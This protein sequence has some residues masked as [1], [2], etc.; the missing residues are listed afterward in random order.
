M[1]APMTR[2]KFLRRAF[3]GLTALGARSATA[4]IPDA[5]ATKPGNPATQPC[6]CKPSAAARGEQRPTPLSP[7][8]A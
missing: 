3:V 2:R 1:S 5:T 6:C 4:A 7:V 8:L